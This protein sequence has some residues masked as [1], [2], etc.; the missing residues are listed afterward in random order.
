MKTTV[1]APARIHFGEGPPRSVDYDDV[2]HA[3]A[4]AFEQARH[5]FLDGNGLP[6]R[7]RGRAAF[8]IVE[9]GFG[10][11]HNL[12]ATV[13]AWLADPDR[14]ARLHLLGIDRH[15]PRREDLARA[16]ASTLDPAPATPATRR[17]REVADELL[18]QWPP[19]TANVHRLTL[20]GGAVRLYLVFADVHDGL[21]ELVASVDAFYLDGFSPA[22]NPQMWDTRVFRAVDRLAAD[23][24][25]AATWSVARVVRDGL[26]SAGFELR[27]I[28]GLGDKRESLA[29]RRQPLP[30]DRQRRPALARLGKPPAGAARIVIVGAGLAGAHVAARLAE[31]GLACSVIDRRGEPASEAS[32]GSAGIFHGTVHGSD[33]LHA[34]LHRAAALDAMSSHRRHA[35]ASRG[36]VPA[37]FGG[38]LRLT[39]APW[40]DMQALAQRLGL[41]PDWARATDAAE[42]TAIAGVTIDQACWF[43]PHGGWIA[44]QALCRH[45]L[46]HPLIRF[47]GGANVAGLQARLGSWCLQ[48]AAGERIIDADVVVI[49]N[50]HLAAQ[51]CPWAHWPL[52]AVRGQS[53]TVAPGSPGLQAPRVALGGN[54]YA[55]TQQDGSVLCGAS[56]HAQDFE[57]QPRDTDVRANL[58]RLRRL[59]GSQVDAN[60]A[61]TLGHRVAWRATTPD[62]LPIVGAVPG[63]EASPPGMQVRHVPRA[64]GLYALTG[65]G[66]RGLTLAPLMAE[67]LVASILHEPI[68]IE[69]SILD[70]IDPARFVAKQ[71]RRPA[72]AS[73]QRPGEAGPGDAEAFTP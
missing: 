72:A 1:I 35:R 16:F 52:R 57:A 56:S 44:P 73:A 15:P 41:P 30:P 23:D 71:A 2:Y 24:A 27:R 42:A 12:L 5:V 20:V 39:D 32:G 61:Q 37:S 62:R 18:D 49:A 6:G 38:L 4:G 67:V 45:L 25:T 66:S 47:I 50:A 58:E 51:L 65:L 59:T 68:P 29:A 43:F 31:R 26:R 40:S 9:T 21:R 28:P 48:D 11:G 8:T 7:W 13:Q 10:L 34:R 14:C 33:N 63:R 17:L 70:A 60:H 54:G 22:K 69:A 55:L 3:A 36:Q 19:L 64:T 46:D 53:T